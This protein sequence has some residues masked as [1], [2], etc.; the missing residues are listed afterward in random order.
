VRRSVLAYAGLTIA[1]L[2][3]GSTF[4]IVK[5]AIEVLPPFAFVGWRFL[6]G[7][8]ALLL[9]ARPRGGTLWRDGAVA[10]L[11]LF[12]GY[13]LQTQGLAATSAANSG[14]ITGLYVVFTPLLAAMLGRR[15]PA[16]GVLAG[17]VVAFVGLA[18]LS[19]G[20]RFTLQRG[21]ALTVGCA[22]AYA[23]HI[24]VLARVAPRHPV[25][26]LTAVQVLV[27]AVLSL[28][29]AAATEGFPLPTAPVAAALLL[30]GLG[31]SA[32]AYLLQV[33]A[34]TIVGP[35]RTAVVLALEPVFA[36]AVAAVVAGERLTG[37]G[38]TGASLIVVGIYA[39]LV[40]T[41]GSDELP[42]AE[43]VTPAH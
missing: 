4:V 40:F 19:A 25:V 5:D 28:G 9:L 34:Q 21:D 16:P 29:A 37:R 3:F 24:V 17:A 30:T 10:G 41:R 38:W 14:L 43:S 7:A 31:V 20:D 42:V 36:A 27:T 13:S 18:L 11:F 35:S 32:G 23:F 26:P 2:L 6:I 12:A 1:A 39:V 8:G 33:W 22:V 15:R